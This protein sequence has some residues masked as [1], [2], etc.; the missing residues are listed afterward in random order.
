M[1]TLTGNNAVLEVAPPGT[2]EECVKRPADWLAEINEVCERGRSHNL[3]LARVVYAA[4]CELRFGQW[5]QM[6][7][8][9]PF[10]RRKGYLLLAV[11]KGLG[12]LKVHDRALLPSALKTLYL[13]SQLDPTVLLHLIGQ[14]AI[15][16]GLTVADVEELLALGTTKSKASP[17]RVSVK[18]HLSKFEA[19]FRKNLRDWT[20][21]S[22]S[23]CGESW[24]N[25]RRR[26]PPPGRALVR[27]SLAY[28][29]VPLRTIT[30]R[31]KRRILPNP[32]DCYE[33]RILSFLVACCS[34]LRC[35]GTG[36]S[37]LPRPTG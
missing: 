20:P 18:R 33:K 1:K 30:C 3:E 37:S 27:Q 8:Q 19:F 10:A 5:T 9:F 6:A 26:L 14:G 7:S 31:Q 4:K 34:A 16:R 24:F 32:V 15:H 29:S 25:C 28:L 36:P 11:G 13:L 2:R 22:E 23:W 35:P 21:G 12:N 17:R